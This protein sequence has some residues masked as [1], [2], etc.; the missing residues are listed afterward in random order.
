MK[1]SC[2][3]WQPH[4][5][6]SQGVAS[7]CIL[8]FSSISKLLVVDQGLQ[9]VLSQT[10]CV[11]DRAAHLKK[12]KIAEK[13]LKRNPIDICYHLCYMTGR[14]Q[15]KAALRKPSLISPLADPY[16]TA[17]QPLLAAGQLVLLTKKLVLQHLSSSFCSAEIKHAEARAIRIFSCLY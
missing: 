12:K 3:T 1:L 5:P 2:R 10:E 11:P 17:F 13:F 15:K 9:L 8:C 16:M 7:A 14:C 6:H 4:S